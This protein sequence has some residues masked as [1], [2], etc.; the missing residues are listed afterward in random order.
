MMPQRGWRL[1]SEDR[2]IAL[3]RLDADDRVR[4]GLSAAHP[5][6]LIARG[7]GGSDARKTGTGLRRK[8]SPQRSPRSGSFNKLNTWPPFVL[9]NSERQSVDSATLAHEI[10]HAA[11]L[12]H[13][14]FNG[15]VMNY[16]PPDRSEFLQP[17]MRKIVE[18]Y[19]CKLG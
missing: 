3:R 11:G 9:I 19:F 6:A 1:R 13:T 4:V 17:E 2:P 7:P 8:P 12:G 16:P 5:T 10:G 18:S 14:A 15:Y